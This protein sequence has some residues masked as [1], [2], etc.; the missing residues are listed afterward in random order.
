MSTDTMDT[1]AV[2]MSTDTMD[3]HAIGASTTKLIAKFSRIEYLSI[4]IDKK[5]GDCTN[6]DCKCEQYKGWNNKMIPLERLRI[7]DIRAKP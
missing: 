7:A 4:D 6:F 2:A 5:A 3:T 1:H